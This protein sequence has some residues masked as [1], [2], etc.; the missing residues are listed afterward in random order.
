[1]GK[2]SV[3]PVVAL[4]VAASLAFALTA[5]GTP[6]CTSATSA[7]VGLACTANTGVLVFVDP[8]VL[9]NLTYPLGSY[10]QDSASLDGNALGIVAGGALGYS[11]SF[12]LPSG[13]HTV[14]ISKTIYKSDGSTYPIVGPTTY[15][16][17]IST[18]Q[19]TTLSY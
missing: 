17:N 1:M 19:T 15:T 7:A 13:S 10:S 5:C 16:E 12:T 9:P 8:D 18:G 6:A 3:K 4:L 11:G 14:V 2:V